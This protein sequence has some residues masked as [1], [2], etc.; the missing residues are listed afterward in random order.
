MSDNKQLSNYLIS[1][2]NKLSNDNVTTIN[3]NDSRL[4][5][6]SYKLIM[7]QILTRANELAIRDQSMDLFPNHIETAMN[8]ILNNID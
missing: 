1:E 2:L 4:L 8:E 6:I 3:K 7:Q 5:L